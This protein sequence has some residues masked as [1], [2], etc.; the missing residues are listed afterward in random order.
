M[1]DSQHRQ[2]PGNDDEARMPAPETTKQPSSTPRGNPSTDDE[3]V[4]KGREV[5]ERVK[6]Y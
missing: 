4:E 1:T 5:L 6:P 3:A 2:D